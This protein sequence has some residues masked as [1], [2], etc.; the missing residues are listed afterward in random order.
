MGRLAR[1]GGK[2]DRRGRYRKEGKWARIG[3]GEGRWK[4]LC[5]LEISAYGLYLR[6]RDVSAMI[7][8]G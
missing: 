8:N 1:L 2:F 7:G 5:V 4:I 3:E 6:H